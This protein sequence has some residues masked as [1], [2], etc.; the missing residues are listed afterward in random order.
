MKK[1]IFILSVLFVVS[2]NQR[3][4][5][6]I[7]GCEYIEDQSYNGN[8]YTTTLAHKGNCSNPIHQIKKDT[9]YLQAKDTIHE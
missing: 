2:C 5:I 1:L 6:V 8:G 3:E 4:V 7:E 9:I